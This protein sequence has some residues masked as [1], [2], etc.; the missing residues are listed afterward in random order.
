M[1]KIIVGYALDYAFACQDGNE[2]G[3]SVAECELRAVY[4]TVEALDRL[5]VWRDARN[6]LAAT[7]SWTDAHNAIRAMDRAGGK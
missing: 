5:E 4:R 1:N 3:A 2:I 6:S 7:L